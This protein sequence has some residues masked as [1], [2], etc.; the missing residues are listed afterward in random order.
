MKTARKAVR[1]PK[2]IAPQLTEAPIDALKLSSSSTIPSIESASSFFSSSIASVSP[3]LASTDILTLAEAAALL[4]CCTKTLAKEAT[5]GNVP[6][7]RVGARGASI[8]L[9]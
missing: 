8:V 7:K 3:R 4:K 9:L 6:A 1:K 5:A 2:L